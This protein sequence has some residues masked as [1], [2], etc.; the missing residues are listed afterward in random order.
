MLTLL[1]ITAG[2][3][4]SPTA[5]TLVIVSVSTTTAARS[6]ALT[7]ASAMSPVLPLLLLLGAGLSGLLRRIMALLV[8]ALLDPVAWTA[9]PGTSEGTGVTRRAALLV[10]LRLRAAGGVLLLGLMLALSLLDI[11]G[12]LAPTLVPI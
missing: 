6:L 5:A 9:T 10:L 8:T 1:L 3:L 12:L 2:L 4:L 7:T 11:G